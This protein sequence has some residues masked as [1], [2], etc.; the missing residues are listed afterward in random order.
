MKHLT[1]LSR[2]EYLPTA[3][4]LGKTHADAFVS[5]AALIEISALYAI[6]LKPFRYPLR[7][8]EEPFVFLLPVL[9]QS[10]VTAPLLIMRRV[11]V[12]LVMVVSPD[13]TLR[14]SWRT[15]L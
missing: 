4:R 10:Q 12:K 8:I 13:T 9:S 14:I 11:S 3:E 2:C 1:I 5:I 6:R 15:V 7:H